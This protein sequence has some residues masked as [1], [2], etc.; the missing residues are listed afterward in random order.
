[1]NWP[2][3]T[4]PA[5]GR[6]PRTRPGVG[7]GTRRSAW[8]PRRGLRRR[9]RA[10]RS[11]GR[12]RSRCS[13]GRAPPA[14]RPDRPTRCGPIRA[15]HR[16]DSAF[17]PPPSFRRQI[18]VSPRSSVIPRGTAR[19]DCAFRA[20]RPNTSQFQCSKSCRQNMTK[21]PTVRSYAADPGQFG[22]GR[23]GSCVVGKQKRQTIRG[24]PNRERPAVECARMHG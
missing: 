19:T 18:A 7:L 1:M 24:R 4:P 20:T 11:S 6:R 10:L 3:V 22:Y 12:S 8:I 15:R 17:P 23:S 21:R 9:R 2:R 16:R 13:A 14:A 5:S